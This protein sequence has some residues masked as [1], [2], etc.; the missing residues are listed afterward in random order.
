MPD[1]KIHNLIS[2]KEF[3]SLI[4]ALFNEKYSTNTFEL[5]GRSGQAQYG[6]DIFSERY[7]TIIQC[8]YK[9][10]ADNK[11][12]KQILKNDIVK[13]INQL[14][15]KDSPFSKNLILFDH[16]ILASTF[17]HDT[18]LQLF[19]QELTDK[20]GNKYPF[21]ISYL[22]WDEIKNWLKNY[23]KIIKEF[24][25]NVFN[26]F[27]VSKYINNVPVYNFADLIGRES[28]I[29]EIEYKLSNN[30]FIV[31]SGVAGIGKTSIALAFVNE[32]RIFDKIGFVYFTGNIVDDILNQFQSYIPN[33]E[34]DESCNSNEN[35][36][37]LI[38][39]LKNIHGNNVIV[40]DGFDNIEQIYKYELLLKSTNWNII[41]TSRTIP[42]DTEK[43][44]INELN[45]ES[46]LRIFYKFY[47]IEKNDSEI[48]EILDIINYHTLVLE[49]IAKV[50]NK[51]GLKITELKSILKN[52]NI[53]SK[54]LQRKIK[55]GFHADISNSERENSAISYL[56][57]IFNLDDLSKFEKE[58]LLYLSCFPSIFIPI[59]KLKIL[60]DINE[61]NG[62]LFENSL[63]DLH[64][65][66]WLSLVD[67]QIKI[68]SLIQLVIQNKLE[69][70]PN[71]ILKIIITLKNEL[72]KGRRQS[73]EDFELYLSL[74]ESIINKVPY[75]DETIG[76]LVNTLAS[77]NRKIGKYERALELAKID[78]TIQSNKGNIIS[79]YLA[80]NNI[81]E[82]YR[83]MH[84]FDKAIIEFKKIIESELFERLPNYF[85]SVVSNNISLAYLG[86]KNYE[87]AY[88]FANKAF[89]TAEQE[90]GNT[91]N[92]LNN[93]SNSDN[94]EAVEELNYKISLLEYALMR[95]YNTL[96]IISDE[97]NNVHE[98]LK[99]KLKSLSLRERKQVANSPFNASI[100]NNIAISY[101]K[102]GNIDNALSFALKAVKLMEENDIKDMDAFGNYYN[103]VASIYIKKKQF[104]L[105]KDFIDK[106]F[107]YINESNPLFIDYCKNKEYI[108]NNLK[109][110][111]KNSQRIGRNDLCPCGSGKKYKHCHG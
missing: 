45:F 71:N 20:N 76:Y 103:T 24:F 13:E 21:T 74:S 53:I 26:D 67:N 27:F 109:Q 44:I 39:A 85:I 4:A 80:I 23:P 48:K 56:F 110:P 5:L 104:K 34:Y 89:E 64:L 105:A 47:L 60:F 2:D 100:Y 65:K 10:N 95:I 87:R 40:I 102:I 19:C 35:F 101:Y 78:Q 25:P 69:L 62:T 32:S 77:S 3:E 70:T 49:L 1:F 98:G 54:E 96:G 51:K 17:Y 63:D 36:K 73:K 38:F 14:T 9:D 91:L 50:A 111:S 33:F 6:I 30:K 106:A 11:L 43:I 88:Y 61:E 97:K 59:E 72:I 8:K 79:E 92:E 93:I 83:E 31:L 84:F 90:I 107:L 75:F 16:F 18:E 86:K 7:K 55:I 58:Y 57:S 12:L 22:G 52:Q 82:G 15:D 99:F 37:K 29:S 94:N 42:D 41:I 66:G 28:I 68:H 46:A 81:G 108:Y